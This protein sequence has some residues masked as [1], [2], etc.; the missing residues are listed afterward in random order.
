M[1]KSLQVL[2]LMLALGAGAAAQTRASAD[3]QF[4]TLAKE[5]IAQLL[6][7][8]PEL[9]TALGDHRDDARLND[10]SLDGVKRLRA[11]NQK[12]LQALEAIPVAQL[13]PTNSVDCRIL[14]SRIAYSLFSADELREYEWNPLYYNT[15]GAVYTLL[16][17]DFAPLSQRLASVKERLRAMPQVVAQAKLNLKNPPRIYTETAIAQNKGAINLIRGEL[18]SFIQ[19]APEMKA[20]VSPA[21]EAAIAALDE[22]G[23]WLESDLLPRSDGEFR[24]GDEKYRRKLR[25][26]LDSDLSKE[27][28][29][30]RAEADLARTQAT[31]YEVALPLYK[32]YFPEKTAAD[33]GDKK[34]IIKA[35]MDKLAEK[36]PTNETIVAQA[37][38]DLKETTDFVRTRE[39]M[40]VPAAPVKIIPM[41]EFQRGVAV[42]SFN[43]TGPLEREGQSY[44]NISPT[45]ENWT[46]QRVESFF[47]EYN[48][49]MVKDLTVHEAMPGH[50][51][52][53][54]HS[55][56]FKAPTMVR[57]IFKS[58]PFTEGW[59]VY[60]E[61]VMAEA[62][63]GGPEVRM[64]QLKMRLRSIIN[65]I[66][67]QKIH[68]AGMTEKEAIELMMS[69]GFQEEGEAAGKWRRANLSSTQLS[70]YYVGNLEVE[71][72]R[73]DY[74]ARARGK[75]NY[76]LLHD[77]MLSF[78][79]PPPKYIR[80]MMKLG[81]GG[82]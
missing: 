19:R 22:Y 37:E 68:T 61:R 21:Q 34:A 18:N 26:A 47:R 60:A 15:A 71:D 40:S 29:L 14:K 28:I 7:F 13:S 54:A 64:Q 48:D 75:V 1:T 66:I 80:E 6:K 17:R 8:N 63:Y 23:K 46:A 3:Q 38:K 49:Y 42:A 41:P 55:N 12:S 62:G 9:A 25:F 11:F 77:T 35:V 39:L 70:T 16:S 2:L 73:R 72:I 58:G 24:L 82:K 56:Q 52:Q 43:S 78:G 53:Q 51:L 44:Y 45:P 59:A 31:M 74:E 30:R 79:S 67:D 76:K 81:N 69:E 65:A 27:E 5:Y 36:H 50:Y 33:G 10:Y 20:E 32:K 57:A 4:E